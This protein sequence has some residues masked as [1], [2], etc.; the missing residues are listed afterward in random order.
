MHAHGGSASGRVVITG[1]GIV[2]SLGQDVDTFYSNLLKV[3]DLG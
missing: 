3:G 1:Q 2:T